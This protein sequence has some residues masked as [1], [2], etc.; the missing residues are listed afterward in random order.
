MFITK[1]SPKMQETRMVCVALSTE[2]KGKLIF[3]PE[4]NNETGTG[5]DER[6]NYFIWWG[7][8]EWPTV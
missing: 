3:N 4:N 5:N 1:V 2:E 7:N 8:L 6:I